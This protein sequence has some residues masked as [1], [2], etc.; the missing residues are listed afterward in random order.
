M[1]LL[2]IE[3]P[4]GFPQEAANKKEQT[5]LTGVAQWVG[6]CPADRKV[7]GLISS[8]GCGP[9]LWLRALREAAD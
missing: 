2:N 6:C 1:C 8:L 7:T 5:S 3:T 9:G 4:V